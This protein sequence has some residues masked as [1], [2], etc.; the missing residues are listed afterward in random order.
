MALVLGLLATAAWYW[1]MLASGFDQVPG[2]RGDAR[3]TVYMVEHWYQV[4]RGNAE[5]LSPAMF[6]PA[7]GTIGYSEAMILHAFPYSGLRL[8]GV[9]MFTALA[10]PVV[11][12]AFLNYAACY[13]LLRRVLRLNVV[14][15]VAG[16]MF[17]A[18]NSPRS[19]HP[20][21]W[22]YQAA[23]LLPIVAACLVRFLQGRMHI[24]QARA[25]GLLAAAAL[26]L[27]VQFLILPY[28]GWFAVFWLLL[29]VPVVLLAPSTRLAAAQVARRFWPAFT[30]AALVFAGGLI[31]FY[32]VYL[33]T[34]KAVGP[35]PYVLANSLT[36][37]AWSL[38]QMGDR[39]YAWGKLAT[40]VDRV[41]PLYSTELNI[42]IGLVPSLA[43]VALLLWSVKTILNDIRHPTAKGDAGT[44]RAFVATV[45]LACA[46]FYAVGMRYWDGASPWR[47]VY[48]L[49]PGAD[50][51]RAIAR[52]VLVLALPIS[53][54]FAMAIHKCLEAISARPAV[55]ARRAMTAGLLGVVAFGIFEQFARPRTFSA[56][57]ELSR[58]EALAAS[59]PD[60][61]A[62][63]FAAA[64]PV[65]VP[66][67]HEYQIDAMLVSA[68]S[69]VP[70]VNGYS[71]HEPPGWTLR[72]VET[73][74]YEQRVARWIAMNHVAG[75]VC[76][77]EI[78]D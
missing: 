52:Y 73:P 26:T 37:D 39:N 3:A 33:R 43:F 53:I 45:I 17:F 30:G 78:A 49:V 48:E 20:G 8:A 2:D 22:A 11:V 40:A 31:P 68:I 69:G 62:V 9:D 64:A 71:G 21:H 58:V 36:P 4:F 14:A 24:T 72:E 27:A 44:R 15:S 42:G 29:L 76:R 38:I 75:P 59:L 67:K 7:K 57:S 77:L 55:L 63:F 5:I 12:F 13:Y 46:L 74:D 35:R 25:F 60:D 47:L 56:R 66:M 50:G 51:L 1:P 32:L 65:Q 61:C 54:G 34:A 19:N 6:Y 16:A 23:F 41:H 70:T 28:Q 10:V 18:F